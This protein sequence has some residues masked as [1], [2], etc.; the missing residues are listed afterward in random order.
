MTRHIK[1][2]SPVDG[3][4]YVD[5]PPAS[6]TEIDVDAVQRAAPRRRLAQGPGQGA[7][8]AGGRRR[9]RAEGDGP[10]DRR[11]ARLAD[12][13]ADPLRPG[14]T[15]RPRRARALHGVDRRRDAARRSRP[16][17]SRPGFERY[18]AREPVGHRLHHRAVELSLPDD[19]QLRR[20][21]ADRRQRRAAEAGG[22]D[23]A[24]RRSLPEG[25]R[26]AAACRRACFTHIVLEH[27]QTEAII[28]GGHVDHVAFT[29]S[30]EGGR[31]WS[32]RRPGPSPPSASNSAAKTRP[33]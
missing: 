19:R 14:R 18:I 11:G 25:V 6:Q 7:R 17:T 24:G 1:C 26:S 8:R 16:R 33:M 27:G 4:V 23:L 21:G 31:A 22:A 30:V 15:A 28:A 12:G 9:R 3:R 32:G 13:S 2:V 5:R 20:A 10:G 29:G